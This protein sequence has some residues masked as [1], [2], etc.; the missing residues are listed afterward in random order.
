MLSAV[1]KVHALSSFLQTQQDQSHFQFLKDRHPLQSQFKLSMH[2]DSQ[3]LQNGPQRLHPQI[4]QVLHVH[5]SRT[6]SYFNSAT[7]TERLKEPQPM[8]VLHFSPQL[9]PQIAKQ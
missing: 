7:S 6:S 8:L 3:R 2:M 9:L 5:R 4:S 1:D